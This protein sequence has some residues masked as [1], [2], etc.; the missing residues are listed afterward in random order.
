MITHYFNHE[1]TP[2][3]KYSRYSYY[4]VIQRRLVYI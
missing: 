2:A 3:A 4:Y 1:T